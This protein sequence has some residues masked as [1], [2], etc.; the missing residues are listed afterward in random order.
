MCFCKHCPRCTVI[1]DCFE[2]FI[3]RPSN[4][5]AKAQT[6]STYK[7]HN[8]VT[9]FIGVTPQ[10]TIS[11]ISEGWGGRVS[12]KHV[13]ESC[14]LLN[15]LIPGDVILADRGFDISESVAAWAATVTLP[16]LQG[17]RSNYPVLMWNKQGVLQMFG[18]M[19][20]V[21]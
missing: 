16:A 6:F 10:G 13:I 21:S 14:G 5:L 11:F 18:Y 19:L 8:T 1:I 7:H 20:N 15:N 2:I 4:Q 12:D 9:Y 3:E 17:E